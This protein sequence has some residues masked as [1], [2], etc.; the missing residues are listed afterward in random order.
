MRTTIDSAGRLVI[1]K[2]LRDETGMVAGEVELVR[3]GAGIRIEPVP[4]TGL[5]EV[6]GRL[7]IPGGDERIDDTTVRALRHADQ[8]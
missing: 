7:V 2:S 1:P 3:D 5:D 6:D 4:G 8:R